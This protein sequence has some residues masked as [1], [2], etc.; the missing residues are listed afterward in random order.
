[1]AQLQK[2]ELVGV[3]IDGRGKWTY[4]INRDVERSITG[5]D[6]A[7]D[8]YALDTARELGVSMTYDP[9]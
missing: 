1:M 5:S 8:G 3:M 2:T 6:A 7:S 9:M 4:D